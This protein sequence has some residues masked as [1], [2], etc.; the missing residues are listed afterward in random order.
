MNAATKQRLGIASPL[1]VK[2][3]GLMRITG[4]NYEDMRKPRKFGWVKW[5][6]GDGG[7]CHDLNSVHEKL[8]KYSTLPQLKKLKT[9]PES[10]SN[11]AVQQLAN[12]LTRDEVCCLQD[13]LKQLD[14]V[15]MNGLNKAPATHSP[16]TAL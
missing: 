10:N 6:R 15:F 2:A 12:S 1:W 3:S 11:W 5:N 14:Q 13:A 16:S 8:M 4:W 9:L 7:I